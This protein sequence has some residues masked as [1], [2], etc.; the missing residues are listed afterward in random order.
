MSKWTSLKKKK[1]RPFVITLMQNEENSIYQVLHLSRHLSI[2]LRDHLF[3]KNVRVR[4]N[5]QVIS[6]IQVAPK[7]VLQR[8][9]SDSCFVFIYPSLLTFDRVKL[10]KS[11]YWPNYLTNI[12]QWIYSSVIC[13][14]EDLQGDT[15]GRTFRGYLNVRILIWFFFHPSPP[16]PYYQMSTVNLY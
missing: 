15:V 2:L 3:F 5:A 16:T 6:N 7:V 4:P 12:Y 14:R 8:I 9:C 1:V 13:Q 11:H 10:L